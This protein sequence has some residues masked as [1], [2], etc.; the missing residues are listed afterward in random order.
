MTK[1][2]IKMSVKC[3]FVMVFCHPAE[4]KENTPGNGQAS[5]SRRTFPRGIACASDSA[6]AQL[7][8]REHTP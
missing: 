2:K 1:P 5:L 8:H 3:H 6:Q 4:Y 7:L